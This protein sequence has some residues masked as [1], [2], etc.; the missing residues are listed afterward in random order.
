MTEWN[1]QARSEVCQVTGRPFTDKEAFYTLLFE[2]PTGD[3]YLRQD[4]SQEAWDSRNPEP[5]P[6]SFWKSEFEPAAAAAVDPVDKNDAEAELR[7]LIEQKDPAQ[8]KLCYLLAL[9]LERKRILK[10]REKIPT[11]GGRLIA[12]EHTRTQ[13]SFLV[14]EVE[15]KLSELDALR[16]EVSGGTSR[17]FAMVSKIA[18]D[19]VTETPTAG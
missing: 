7:R 18:D 5:K 10:A 6:L 13:E 9:L 12:Y 16:Q 8:A 19:P 11:P 1:I 3:G 14:P 17:I 15:F 4:L 2:T